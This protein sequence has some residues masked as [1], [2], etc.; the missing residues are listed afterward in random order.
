[1]VQSILAFAAFAALLTVVP[2]ADT[3]LV[4]RANLGGGRRVAFAG[5]SASAWVR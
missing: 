1:M 2:G 3:A 4:I 5:A